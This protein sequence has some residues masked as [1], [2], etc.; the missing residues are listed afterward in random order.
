MKGPSRWSLKAAENQ[1][2]SNVYG[3]PTGYFNYGSDI[4]FQL[5]ASKNG[6]WNQ[7]VVY[8]FRS[9]SEYAYGDNANSG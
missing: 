5:T 3:P 7:K 1:Y 6:S 9:V 4:A 2:D 8:T